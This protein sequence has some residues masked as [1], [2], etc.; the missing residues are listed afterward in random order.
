[1]CDK[2]TSH[3]YCVEELAKLILYMH[4]AKST[5]EKVKNRHFDIYIY[6]QYIKYSYL[7]GKNH[8]RDS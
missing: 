8:K 4:K 5:T 6:I 1:M 3:V 2:T 7:K